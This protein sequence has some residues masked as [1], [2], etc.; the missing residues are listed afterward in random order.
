MSKLIIHKGSHIPEK[1]KIIETGNSTFHSKFLGKTV[2]F[3]CSDDGQKI[4]GVVT[5]NEGSELIVN[6]AVPNNDGVLV[7]AK[8]SFTHIK[9]EDATVIDAITLSGRDVKSWDSSAVMKTKGFSEVKDSEGNT[10]DYRDVKIEGYASTFVETTPE[11]RDGDYI[12]DNA[13]DRTLKEFKDNPVMLID[14][15]RTVASMMGSYSKI[16]TNKTGLAISGNLTNSPHPEALHT[17]SLVAE[18][19]LKT[20]SIGGA[21]FYADDYRGIEEVK[22]ME[23]SLVVVPANPDA[24]FHVRSIDTDFAE[25]AFK[26]H[27][28]MHG[29]EVRMKFSPH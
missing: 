12:M 20:L 19:H 8:D 14:H 9:P 5:G 17:R 25:K 26:Y 23:I 18:G 2:F 21:F 6:L 22:L 7:R 1:P 29:G 13:F 28:K 11:D 10:I 4:A 16:S 27:S 3:R 15:R 24:T